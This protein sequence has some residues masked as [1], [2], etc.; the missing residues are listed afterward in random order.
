MIKNTI[1]VMKFSQ[2]E[3][4]AMNKQAKSEVILGGD[5]TLSDP[6]SVDRTPVARL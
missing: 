2:S 4:D 5:R 6:R 1:T 3:D